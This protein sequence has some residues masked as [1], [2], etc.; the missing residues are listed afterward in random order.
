M[1]EIFF[2]TVEL[3]FLHEFEILMTSRAKAQYT[4]RPAEN[5]LLI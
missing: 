4:I 5:I 3:Y 2:K 1:L